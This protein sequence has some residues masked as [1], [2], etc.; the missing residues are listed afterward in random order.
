MSDIRFGTKWAHADYGLIVAPYAIPMPEPQTNF[1]EIPGRDGALDLSEAFGTVRYA[2]RIIPLTLY[3]R[4]PFDTLLSAFAAD[5]HG[6]RMIVIFDRDPNFYYNARITIE[7]AERHWGYCELSL[8]C[9]AKPYKLEQ[10]ET[11]ITVLPTGSATVTLTN[12]R[13]PVVPSITV[14]AEM[15]LTFTIVGKDYSVTLPAGTHT[16]PS[17]VLLEGNTEIVITGTGSATFAYRKGAL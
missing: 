14:S 5:V 6:R 10:F 7:D 11:T 2:D 4:A 16:V 17:L 15:T 9:R 12:K 1:V 3:A 8:E 13:M